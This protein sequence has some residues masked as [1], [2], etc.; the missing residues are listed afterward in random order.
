[1]PQASQPRIEIQQASALLAGELS[2]EENAPV[3]CRHQERFID[4]TPWSL[5]TS[6]YPMS[7][8]DRGALRLIQAETSPRA[9]SRTCV[10]HSTSSR[11]AT[12]T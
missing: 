10:N 6:F 3:V 4:G 12:A 1:M 7:L 11:P 5:Q 2:I 9:P 8:V